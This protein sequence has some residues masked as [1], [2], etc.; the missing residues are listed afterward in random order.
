MTKRGPLSRR[1]ISREHARLL[2]E[3]HLSQNKYRMLIDDNLIGA[4]VTNFKG[5]VTD[6]NDAFLKLIGYSREELL[7]GQARWDTVT[8][9]AFIEFEMQQGDMARVTGR[10]IYEK[11][12]I[13]RDGTRVP[14]LLAYSVMGN[15]AFCFAVD[16]TE[17][18]RVQSQLQDAIRAREDFLSIASHELKTPLTTLYLQLG[19]LR[20][21]IPGEQE[22]EIHREKVHR[23]LDGLEDQLTR[24]G[25]LVE[26]LLDVT[27]I[28]NNRLE[29]SYTRF[30]LRALTQE[31]VERLS[32][33]AK[34]K[35]SQISLGLGPAVIG[36]WD[37][38]RIDQVL[39]NLLLNA[40]K[41]GNGSHIE[42]TLT[43]QPAHVQIEVKD[44]GI[45]IS[46]E[47]Q[48]RVFDR[49]E[50][51]ASHNYGGLGLGLFITKRFVERHGGKIWLQSGLKKGSTFFVELPR[52]RPRTEPSNDLMV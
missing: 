19:M 36:A 35:G 44:Q 21:L 43:S 15:E 4:A 16:L 48:E 30:D 9:P 39:T 46:A 1:K 11:E 49:F 40:V 20:R 5:E 18:K 6:A 3:L 23:R 12:Y 25:I 29:L 10:T 7:A 45:G 38:M 2:D 24:L 52:E 31:V 22:R 51:A 50:R 42:V 13:R 28:R 26:S 17:Q 37:K 27:R 41:Y 34:R 47:D 8:D 14:V 32:E 33:E